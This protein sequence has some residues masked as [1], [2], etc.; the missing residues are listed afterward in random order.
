M[1]VGEK[2]ILKPG[3]HRIGQRYGHLIDD[4]HIMGRDPFDELK[5]TRKQ[6]PVNVL[7]TPEY[8]ALEIPV[9]GFKKKDISIELEDHVLIIKGE[10]SSDKNRPDTDYV[11]REH[12]FAVFERSFE[13]SKTVDEENINAHVENGMLTITLNHSTPA[14]KRSITHIEVT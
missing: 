8:Y 7:S 14:A 2:F 9:P 6:I 10:R 12:N 5:L 11:R 3:F 13:L 1:N 4:K